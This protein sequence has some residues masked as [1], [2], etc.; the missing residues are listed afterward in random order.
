[1]GVTTNA[2]T[3]EAHTRVKGA[4]AQEGHAKANSVTRRSEIN[5]FHYAN[6]PPSRGLSALV[7][8]AQLTHDALLV[9]E[10]GLL[11]S[12]E[13]VEHGPL[14]LRHLVPFGDEVKLQLVNDERAPAVVL[15]RLDGALAALQHVNDA[16]SPRG[17][18][19][20]D[21][22]LGTGVDIDGAVRCLVLHRKRVSP[23][24]WIILKRKND[25]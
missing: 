11:C 16:A 19:G 17:R 2:H 4:P 9:D 20:S 12:N 24:R 15:L 18:K 1:M 3:E 6:H 13:G 8:R 25:G 7:M 14:L 23:R 10:P 22:R 21:V 5:I